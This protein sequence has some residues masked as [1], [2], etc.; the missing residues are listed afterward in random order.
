MNG[1]AF[2]GVLL[3]AY[4][5]G[6]LPFSYLAGRLAKGVDLRSVGSGNLGATNAIRELGWSWGLA[7]LLLDA[8]KGWAAVALAQAWGDAGW[9]PVLAGLAAIVGHSFTPYLGFKGGKGVATSAG[10]FLC[11]APDVMGMAL[12]VF[13]TVLLV[14]RRVSVASLAAATALPLFILLLRPHD[15]ALLLFGLLAALLIWI[16]H[17]ANL[18][19][20][21]RGEE[22]RF[23]ITRKGGE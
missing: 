18:G 10:V 12:L 3:L 20:L 9:L 5:L 8:A 4:A 15:G 7:V 22:P 17:H 23:S 6:G 13:L 21:L 2:S 16:R 11:L 19:R 14:L 1:L